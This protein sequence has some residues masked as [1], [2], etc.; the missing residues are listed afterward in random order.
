VIVYVVLTLLLEWGTER[1]QAALLEDHR[2]LVMILAGLA[3]A[4]GLL[5]RRTLW[6]GGSPE[7]GLEFEDAPAPAV[8]VLGLN[9]DGTSPV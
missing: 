9:R 8:M 1:E 2:R 5:R 3:I 4:A 7:E 6:Q